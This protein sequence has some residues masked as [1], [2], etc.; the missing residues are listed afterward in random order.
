MEIAK[1][2]NLFVVEDNAQSQEALFDNKKTGSF[3]DINA[4]SF[5]PGKNLGAFGDGGAVT[6]FD[7]ELARKIRLIANYGSSEKYRHEVQGCNSRLDEL[8]AAFLSVKLAYLDE[9]TEKRRQIARV[10]NE[11]L[12]QEIIPYTASWAKACLV[13]E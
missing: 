2:H 3:G 12:P 8:Q 11:S 4:T 13:A 5:Y 6:T 1:K 9:W 7:T 10:Y